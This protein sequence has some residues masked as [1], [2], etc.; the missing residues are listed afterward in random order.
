MSIEFSLIVPTYNRAP[1]LELTLE[2]LTR[3]Q[4]PANRWEIVVIDDGSTDSTRELL[5]S[6]ES[7]LPLRW[8]TQ[9]NAGAGAARNHAIREAEGLFALF[10]DDDVLVPPELL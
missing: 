6:F 3:V 1:A 2:H 10:V 8:K 9:T 7:R 4:Y 5:G